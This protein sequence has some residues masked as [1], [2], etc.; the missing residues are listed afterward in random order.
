MHSLSIA[1]P[2]RAAPSQR[3]RLSYRRLHVEPLEER[4]LLAAA[5]PWSNPN[6][7]LDVNGDGFISPI[8]ALIVINRLNK[9]GTLPDL[10]PG[11]SE[12]P[13]YYDTFP[14]DGL[15]PLD[16]LLVLSRLNGDRTG[17]DIALG[18][19]N[20]TAPGGQKNTDGVTSDATIG[21]TVTD[22]SKILTL[23][24]RVDSGPATS[25]LP[26]LG[27]GGSLVLSPATLAAL[28]GAPLADGPHVLYLAGMDA[29]GQT[30]TREVSFTLKTGSPTVTLSILPV[31]DDVT[32]Q[33]TVTAT[34]PTPLPNGT[35]VTIDADLNNDGQYVGNELNY[36]TATLFNGAAT[37]PIAP[38]LPPVNP[39]GGADIVRLKARVEDIAG[40]AGSAATTVTIDTATST[41]LKDYV[42][43]DDGQFAYSKNTTVTGPGYTAY[44]MDMTS[45]QWRSPTESSR[46]IWQHW[47]TIVVPDGVVSSTALLFITGGSI[48]STPPTSVDPNLAQAAVLTRS[49][50]ITLR[51]V[52]NEPI[53]FSDE[54][55]P[56][57]RSE[58]EIIAYTYD[59]FLNDPTQTDWPLLLP[60]VKSAVKTM[61][62]VQQYVPT[63]T[64]GQQINDF[65]VSGASKRGW[66][67][68]LTAAVDDRVRA[69]VPMVFDALNLD[70]QMQHHYGVYGFFSP[71][72]QDYEEMRV[73]D[74]ILTAQG[75]ELGKI[76]DPYTYLYAGR[77][78]IPKLLIDSPGDEFFVSD[79]AQFYI[80]DLP[81]QTY[82]RYIPNTGHGLDASA[83]DS[84]TTFFAAVLTGAPLPQFSWTIEPDGA[85]RV[86][87]A[88]APTQVLMW[89]ATNPNARD[90]RQSFNPPDLVKYT[91]STLTDQGGGVYVANVATP[92]TGARA[93]FVELTFPSPIAGVPYK[94][95]TEVRVATNQPLFPWPFPIYPGPGAGAAAG[96][97]GLSMGT[98]SAAVTAAEE[99]ARGALLSAL[100]HATS[101]AATGPV[102]ASGLAAVVGRPELVVPIANIAQPGD[103]ETP[104]RMESATSSDTGIGSAHE[105]DAFFGSDDDLNSAIGSGAGSSLDDELLLSLS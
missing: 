85:I 49:V 93:F 99:S 7:P 53:F 28:K 44:V 63:V 91:S 23:T 55:P 13:P 101:S 16:A 50:M 57:G 82:L 3:G 25:L 35:L 60:M 97:A 61:D 68:W 80:H 14:D 43:K 52:P 88:T 78:N 62:M 51:D 1:V 94:F 21:G 38:S 10:T 54:T 26:M 90:F 48:S 103:G 33:V 66:T 46:S 104:S 17:P 15:A 98:N 6:E 31:I 29:L 11:T 105:R 81:G 22:Q 4:R 102:D 59:K 92:A 39:G 86:Q 75:I 36:T 47:V 30:T 79:S 20:D 96:L 45:Q 37:F 67:T 70:E 87:T 65:V 41:A 2:R 71:A 69:I 56:R 72:I 5:A 95:T 84:L 34:A 64:G 9:F 24:G 12:P 18:L 83:G 8:D 19:A 58:D 74:R 40:N 76:V 27:Q 89:Q 42:Q 32:P 77:Y 73:F 100:S